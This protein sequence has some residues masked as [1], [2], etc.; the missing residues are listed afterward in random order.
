MRWTHFYRPHESMSTEE[1]VWGWIFSSYLITGRILYEM[2]LIEYL[3]LMLTFF[4]HFC[5]RKQTVFWCYHVFSDVDEQFSL[6][7]LFQYV[8]RCHVSEG[9]FG[10]GG[11]SVLDHNDCPCD[12]LLLHPLTVCLYGFYSN[13]WLLRKKHKHLIWW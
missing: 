3:N 7:E 4:T 12:V 1:E 9:L 8:L 13:I 2:Y 11:H 5:L 10:W 6:Q